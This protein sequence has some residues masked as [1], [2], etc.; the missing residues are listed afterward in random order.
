[1]TQKYAFVKK[2][3]CKGVVHLDFLVLNFYWHMHKIWNI[4]KTYYLKVQAQI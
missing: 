4:D 3:T 1:M 2:N